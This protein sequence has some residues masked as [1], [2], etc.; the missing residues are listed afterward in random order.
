MGNVGVL[1]VNVWDDPTRTLTTTKFPFWSAIITQIEEAISIAADTSVYVDIQPL[2]GEVWLVFLDAYYEK[3]PAK[4]TYHDYDGSTRRFQTEC[5]VRDGTYGLYAPLL[6][7][8]CKILTNGLF[9]S[10]RFRNAGSSEGTGCYGYSGFKLSQPLWQPERVSG[11]QVPPFKRP[12]NG[13]MVA[14]SSLRDKAYVNPDDEIAYHL[15]SEDLA[16]C[17]TTGHVVE[18]AEYHVLEKDLVA[19]IDAFKKDPDTTGWRRIFDK[20]AEEGI[21]L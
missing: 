16:R 19:N 5:Y 17:P 13:R 10:L 1:D 4:V 18:R 2:S 6:T 20:L 8:L 14:F 9:A 15:Y 21:S 3:G 11:L 12:L 7:G